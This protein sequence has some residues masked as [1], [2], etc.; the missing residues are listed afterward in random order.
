MKRILFLL[1]ALIVGGVSTLFAQ[2]LI[3]KW[4]VM[5]SAETEE[6]IP[7]S[8]TMTFASN[9][10]ATINMAFSQDLEEVGMFS[11]S[12]SYKGTY[13]YNAPNC[14][15][16]FDSKTPNIDFDIQY[17][18]AGKALIAS[19]PN[20]KEEISNALREGLEEVLKQDGE[21]LCSTFKDRAYVVKNLTANSFDLVAKKILHFVR[22]KTTK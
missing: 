4:N 7:V 17:N 6:D 8:I 10:S 2:S 19:D 18:E 20:M 12:I 11:C 16:N 21:E 13:N 5:L 1:I 14:K 22:V 9:N 15:L 3:G